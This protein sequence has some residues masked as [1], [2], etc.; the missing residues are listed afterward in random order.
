[1]LVGVNAS[2]LEFLFK[3]D[4]VQARDSTSSDPV[5]QMVALEQMIKD[6]SAVMR[7]AIASNPGASNAQ[8]I[9]CPVLGQVATQANNV[10]DGCNYKDDQE[11]RNAAATLGQMITSLRDSAQSFECQ[12]DGVSALTNIVDMLE[13]NLD[14]AS[15][16]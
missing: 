10:L 2:P 13:T 4:T 6:K 16:N 12:C 7:Q 5:S 1:M 9:M 8:K 14:V 11:V 3:G 15:F